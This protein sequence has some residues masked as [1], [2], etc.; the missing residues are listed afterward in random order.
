MVKPE[1]CSPQ[2]KKNKKYTC[3]SNS[4]LYQLKHKY[5]RTHKQRINAN[6]PLDIWKELNSKLSK[7]ST[8]S[9]WSKEL[10]VPANDVFAPKSPTSWK[11]NKNEWLSS[12]EITEVLK[13]YEKAY[14]TF[15][16]IGASP[17][18]YFFKEQNGQCVCPELCNLNV[19]KI[20]YKDI[21][22]VFNLDEH[23]GEGTH[24]V[25]V[26]ID[27][28]KKV[29]YYFDSAGEK[30]HKNINVLVKQIQN[31][32]SKYTFEENHPKEHQF[33]NTECGMYALFFII[34]MLKTH[35]YDYFKNKPSFPDEKIEKLRK[36]Y[37]NS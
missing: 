14:P 36:K 2:Q 19:N 27:R 7:C 17:S 20:R 35:N 23:D 26:F 9:C 18:D 21:G 6:T 25:S 29:I 32:D 15:K 24:W 31:Q 12:V 4:H 28:R 13:Q 34:T 37:F 16:Y 10:N 22:I 5:N 8:E 30:I 11:K 3:Y 33:K 1:I